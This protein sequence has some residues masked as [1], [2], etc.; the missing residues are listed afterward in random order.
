MASNFPSKQ[1]VALEPLLCRNSSVTT[2]ALGAS[3]FLKQVVLNTYLMLLSVGIAVSK[4]HIHDPC[5]YG[6]KAGPINTQR[7]V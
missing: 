1:T 5:L 4:M 7:S 3:P 2:H 6:V